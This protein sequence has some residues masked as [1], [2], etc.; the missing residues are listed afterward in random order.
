MSM[1][2][3][4]RCPG[5]KGPAY[6][7]CCSI[8]LESEFAGSWVPVTGP[9]L[10]GVHVLANAAHV[11]VD[12]NAAG[13]DLLRVNTVVGVEVLDLAVWENPASKEAPPP[14][15]YLENPPWLAHSLVKTAIGV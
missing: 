13:V 7:A 3:A 14:S 10:D 12:A 9:H 15:R 2:P 8:K 6:A 4:A 5:Q 11:L 1:L